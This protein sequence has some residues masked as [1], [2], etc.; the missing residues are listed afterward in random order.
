MNRL[1]RSI[2]RAGT[3][4]GLLAISC[5]G[6][7]TGLSAQTLTV[8][9]WG[10]AGQA[11]QSK[12][13]F[14]PFAAETGLTVLQDSWG[15]GYGV[16]KAKADSG[17]V[18][19]DVIQVEAD[20]LEL[21]CA[22]G[23]YEKLD[24]SVVTNRDEFLPGT[25]TDC[26]MGVLLWSFSLDYNTEKLGGEVPESWADYWDTAK[27]PGKRSMRKSAKG[28]VEIALLA[29]GVPGDEIYEVLSTP[30]GVDR[31]FAKL[32]EIKSDIIWWESGSQNV[33]L[34]ASGEAVMGS[35]YDA[36]LRKVVNDENLP[37][38]ITF[39]GALYATDYWVIMTGT[40]READAMKMVAF[41][42]DA[43]RMAQYPMNVP[44]GV[45]NT[46]AMS[47]VPEEL[48]PQLLASEGNIEMAVPIDTFFWI[49]FGEELSKRFTSWLAQ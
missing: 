38:D 31:A 22:D 37:I 11:A 14:E 20:E 28:A 25:T 33:Q 7:A 43:T 46:V 47:M 4:T 36:S 17:D 24:W 18:N 26:G 49:D 34:L 35:A 16:L 48:K 3:F 1:L 6:I 45:P 40:G 9:A 2:T 21:G 15:G 29:D 39:N 12:I 13:F 10:G 8:V 32:D 27:F 5:G 44:A 23:I 30:E 42:S 41:M 19:W